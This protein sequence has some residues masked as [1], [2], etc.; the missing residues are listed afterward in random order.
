MKC[1]HNGYFAL[2]VVVSAR[3][4]RHAERQ[5]AT[6]GCLD[7]AD[8]IQGILNMALLRDLDDCECAIENES[9]RHSP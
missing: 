1:L 3:F 5:A 2:T 8:Y 9:Q 7:A 6:F 4:A